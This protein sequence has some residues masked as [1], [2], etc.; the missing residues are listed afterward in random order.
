MATFDAVAEYPARRI[1]C[2]HRRTLVGGHQAR[3]AGNVGGENGSEPLSEETLAH[4]SVPFRSAPRLAYVARGSRL[5]PVYRSRP[6][7]IAPQTWR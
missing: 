7:P 3:I 1:K 5:A 4:L 6:A 2:R